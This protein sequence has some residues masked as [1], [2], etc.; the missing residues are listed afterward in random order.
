MLPDEKS[1]HKNESSAAEGVLLLILN[2]WAFSLEAFLHRD[3]GER[4]VG[5]QGAAVI[6][7]IPVYCAF[8]EGYNLT[9]MLLL[10]PAYLVMC[11]AARVEIIRRRRRGGDLGHSYYSGWPRIMRFCPGK[12]MTQVKAKIEPL[13]VVLLGVAFCTCYP[14]LGVYLMVGAL[15]MGAKTNG[16]TVADRG[17]DLDLNDLVIEQEVRAE[18]FRANRRN[19]R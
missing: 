19:R 9:P 13:I 18:R 12:D 5:A 8:W 15:C 2:A 11:I 6:A 4:Y 17:L 1:D 7:L 3:F 14:P 10:L 16:E